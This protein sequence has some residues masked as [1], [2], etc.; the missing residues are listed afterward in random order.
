MG[1]QRYPWEALS[2]WL[3]RIE[4][5]AGPT[6]PL[7]IPRRS[8]ALHYRYRFDPRG[9]SASEK[10]RMTS[11]ISAWLSENHLKS[12]ALQKSPDH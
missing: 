2:I 9:L 6:V 4:R 1:L 7:D 5:T 12:A 8:L 11:M 3:N 10:S